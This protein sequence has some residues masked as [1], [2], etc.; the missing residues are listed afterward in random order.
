MDK[1]TNRLLAFSA[2][3]T[4]LGVII[5]LVIMFGSQSVE[6]D[7]ET[8]YNSTI[9][10]ET[11]TEY[12]EE[13]TASKENET[14]VE[15]ETT[16]ILYVISNEEELETTGPYMINVNRLQNVITIYEKD[17]AGEF[18]VPVKAM[19]CSCGLGEKT[20]LGSFKTTNYYK[21]RPLFGNV[22]GQYAVRFNDSILFHSVPYF[23]Q[24][25]GTLEYEE[26]NKLGEK[27]S[28]GCVRLSVADA[29]WIHDNCDK[30]TVVNVY[31]SEED[32]PLG[33]PDTIK[34][35][36]DSEYKDWDPTDDNKNNPWLGKLQTYEDYQDMYIL[37]DA[38]LDSLNLL[39]TTK[40]I[41][42]DGEE[43]EVSIDYS[44]VDASKVGEYYITYSS[45]GKAGATIYQRVKVVI[46][47]DF[48]GIV[49]ENN[50]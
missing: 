44:K 18:T 33:K 41:D 32:E 10:E 34:I 15:E 39:E 23:K 1:L 17:E 7:T 43:L 38:D 8:E 5:L 2:I 30:S 9:K 28:L 12:S 16:K 11:Q 42:Y 21:W 36:L 31:D 45:T 47:E 40:A 46:V 3:S 29:K 37:K 13:E 35:S 20:E 14:L 26:Y 27:A 50:I 22:F 24:N 4:I 25:R 49:L 48:K 19:T 6:A